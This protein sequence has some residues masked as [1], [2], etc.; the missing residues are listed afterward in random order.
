MVFEHGIL[1]HFGL[2]INGVFHLSSFKGFRLKSGHK[3]EF[4]D[5][6]RE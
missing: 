5:V 3:I 4:L 2:Q 6:P 1:S